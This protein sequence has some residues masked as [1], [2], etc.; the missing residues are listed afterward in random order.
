MRFKGEVFFGRRCPVKHDC[1]IDGAFPSV[2]PHTH[3][4]SQIE[5]KVSRP[6]DAIIEKSVIYEEYI[7]AY[8]LPFFLLIFLFAGSTRRGFGITAKWRP[9]KRI[10][11]TY[12][13]LAHFSYIQLA[14]EQLAL[15]WTA[16]SSELLDIREANGKQNIWHWLPVFPPALQLCL[17][18]WLNLMFAARSC[19]IYVAGPLFP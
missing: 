3:D 14:S 6:Q 5:N 18:N 12:Y 17:L 11:G 9:S 19:H 4:R 13:S 1:V 8:F 10:A 2:S 16:T 15:S 7:A